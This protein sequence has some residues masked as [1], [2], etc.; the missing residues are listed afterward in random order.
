MKLV[1]SKSALQDFED[2][3]KYWRLEF[4]KDIAVKIRR[5]LKHDANLLKRH[6][7][8]GF[9]EPLLKDIKIVE[10]RALIV[11][12]TKIIYTVHTDCIYIHMI[13]SCRKDPESLSIEMR[14]R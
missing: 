9:V 13:W 2:L 4:G 12:N 3:V 11:G 6:P 5:K 1:W 7:L 10:H 14:K 8:L